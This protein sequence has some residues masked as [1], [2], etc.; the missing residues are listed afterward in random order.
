MKFQRSPVSCGWRIRAHRNHPSFPALLKCVIIITFQSL[1][2]VGPKNNC[3]ASWAP[4]IGFFFLCHL[5]YATPQ[6]FS[7]L[8]ATQFYA[9]PEIIMPPLLM[10]P[11]FFEIFM[12]PFHVPPWIFL[13]QRKLR[14]SWGYID[15][16]NTFIITTHF[17][18]P[19]HFMPPSKKMKSLCH[20][21]F[22]S[23]SKFLCHPFYATP[24]VA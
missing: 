15:I 12:A 7:N 11:P 5:F 20:P 10:P 9:T 13:F 1:G 3:W 21:F 16:F 24:G 19:H 2:P 22:M 14:N 23:P 8:Y 6:K 18:M 4:T 17:F